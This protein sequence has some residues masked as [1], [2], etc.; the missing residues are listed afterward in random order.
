MPKQFTISAKGVVE[1]EHLPENPEL[2][3]TVAINS[4]EH[5]TM[6]FT[7]DTELSPHVIRRLSTDFRK[8]YRQWQRHA[9]QSNHAQQ[10]NRLISKVEISEPVQSKQKAE[11]SNG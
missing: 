6:C 2:L 1:G 10:S 4:N 3:V 11:V 9:W 5:C 7:G 8:A